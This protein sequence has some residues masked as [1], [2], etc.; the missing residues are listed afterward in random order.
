MSD[1]AGWLIASCWIIF[2]IF[3]VISAF[4][5]KRTVATDR[6]WIWGWRGLTII[7]V[8]FLLL[9]YS[10]PLPSFVTDTSLW[11][12][13]LL[14]NV[15]ADIIVLLGL[16]V[17]L[18]GRITLGRNWNM[19][20]SLQGHHELIE[21]GPYVYVRHPMYSGLVLMLLGTVIWYGTLPGFIFF[22]VCVFGTW[23]KWSREEKILTKH[24][25]QNY[26]DY[27][28]RVRALIPFIW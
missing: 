10:V 2:L 24:F 13:S 8:A 27:Q 26:L 28:K 9:G 16:I 20:P 1:F 11:P 4:S 17:A 22:A 25:G 6:Y 23:L 3:I 5:A 19:Y 15:I 12:H 14:V 21:A 18:W 7:I